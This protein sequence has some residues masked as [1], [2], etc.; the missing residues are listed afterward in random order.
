[1]PYELKYNEKKRQVEGKIT[2]YS[3]AITVIFGN[4]GYDY[5]YYKRN[6]RWS[7]TNRFNVHI[8]MNG[9]LQLTF[10]SMTRLLSDLLRVKIEAMKMLAQSR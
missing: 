1:M 5:K 3:S 10:D 6:D 8:A 7:P 2:G 4:D 9:P